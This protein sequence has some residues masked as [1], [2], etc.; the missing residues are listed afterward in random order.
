MKCCEYDPRILSKK[1][2]SWLKASAVFHFAKDP[3]I[4]ISVHPS[5]LVHSSKR[6]SIIIVETP[7]EIWLYH[8]WLFFIKN[9]VFFLFFWRCFIIFLIFVTWTFYSSIWHKYCK[10][11]YVR[12]LRMFTALATL[13]SLVKYLWIRLWDY[14]TRVE[15]LKGASLW[16]GRFRP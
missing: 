13:S 14:P 5:Q 12:N 3:N 16:Y 6:F 9:E 7:T 8:K 4:W 15:H 1:Q 10:T 2:L 11:F